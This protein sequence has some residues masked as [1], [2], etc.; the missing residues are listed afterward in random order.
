LVGDMVVA[1]DD[2]GDRPVGILVQPLVAD[3]D[4]LVVGQ[5]CRRVGQ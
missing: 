2:V 3:A 5:A 4:T 1:V